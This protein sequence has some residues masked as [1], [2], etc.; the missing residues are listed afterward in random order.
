M[1]R[2]G[3]WIISDY[4]HEIH[5]WGRAGTHYTNGGRPFRWKAQA[6]AKLDEW[7]T[8][9]PHYL[10]I[11]KVKRLITDEE[12]QSRRVARELTR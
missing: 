1:R 2:G 10:G 4:P 6:Q 11:H 8:K 7:M 12:L 5:A 3:W 9:N